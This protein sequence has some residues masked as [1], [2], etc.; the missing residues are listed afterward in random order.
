MYIVSADSHIDTHWLPANLFTDNCS[1]AMRERM[2]FVTPTPEG[3]RW[4]TKKGVTFGLHGG[5]GGM[6]KPYIKGSSYRADRMAEAGLYT[7]SARGIFRLTDPELRIKD[8]DR[9]GV[10]AEVLYGILGASVWLQDAEASWEMTRIYNDWLVEFCKDYPH[11][12]LGLASIPT[13]SPELAAAEIR[14]VARRGGIAGIDVA[15]GEGK[16]KPLYHEVW[17]DFWNAIDESG[18]PV[19]FHTLGPIPRVDMTGFSPLDIERCKAE[20]LANCQYERACEVLRETILGGVLESHPNIKLVLSE[21]GIGW[22]PYMLERMD[23][24]WEDQYKSRLTLKKPPS[25]YWREQCYATYQIEMFGSRVID[26]IGEDNVMW[27]SDFP[28]PDGLWPDSQDVIAAQYKDLDA[29]IRSKV[30]SGNAVKLYGLE[31]AAVARP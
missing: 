29:R 10:S 15:G 3:P 1:A 9:D 26:A 14:R 5:V 20:G 16:L 17:N 25:H 30:L 7:D 31:T 18:L 13:H 21:S 11:R 28:H 22:I 19:H 23:L 6:G 24:N 8:Q 2:P 27:A 4:V 12:L